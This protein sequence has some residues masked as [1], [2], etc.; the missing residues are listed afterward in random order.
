[1]A[2][3]ALKKENLLEKIRLQKD[4]RYI[5]LIIFKYIFLLSI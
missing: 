1:L 5:L 4:R 3:N 2:E